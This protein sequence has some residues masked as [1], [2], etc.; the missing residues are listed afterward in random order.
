VRES[1][2]HSERRA[3]EVIAKWRVEV[4]AGVRAEVR[5]ERRAEAGV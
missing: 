5:E 3:H 2:G 4:R 1:D